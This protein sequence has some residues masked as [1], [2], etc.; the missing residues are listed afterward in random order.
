MGAMAPVILS[1]LVINLFSCPLNF[2]LCK[3]LPKS[4]I[5]LKQE[6]KDKL[7]EQE[8]DINILVKMVIYAIFGNVL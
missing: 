2:E 8:E 5:L 6:V 1:H 7:F 3:K 4:L